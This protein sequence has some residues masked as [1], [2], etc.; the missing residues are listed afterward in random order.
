MR[1]LLFRGQTRRKGEKILNM[2]G[3]PAPSK[4]E[5]EKNNPENLPL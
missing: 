3:D 1:E 5:F 2:R 4:C